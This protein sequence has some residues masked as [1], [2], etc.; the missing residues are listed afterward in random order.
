VTD[1]DEQ[2]HRAAYEALAK[3]DS[4]PLF[5]RVS[6]DYVQHMTAWNLTVHGR[7]RTQ[8]LIERI[9]ER[10]QIT[11]YRLEHV[12]QHGDFVISL[13]SGRSAL[14]ADEFHGVDVVRPGPD[15]LAVE[16]WAH[17][18]PLPDGIDIRQLLDWHD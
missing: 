16:G 1:F 12:M 2:Q 13:I 4:D 14:R 6:D 7:E 9:F 5:A 10:L 8:D 3:G 15:G 17:R 18:P 11:D